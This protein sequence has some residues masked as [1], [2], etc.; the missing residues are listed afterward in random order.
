MDGLRTPIITNLPTPLCLDI[1]DDDPV[2]KI[3]TAIRDDEDLTR[4]S[5]I[6]CKQCEH[7][8]TRPEELLTINDKFIHCFTNPAGVTFEIQCYKNAPGVLISGKPTDFFS[9]FPG[10]HWQYSYCNHC[11]QHLGWYFTKD[12]DAFYGLNVAALKGEI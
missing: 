3:L 6:L 5:G 7:L 9:W 1:A 11:N 4:Q 12:E 2:A 8:I 10:Y